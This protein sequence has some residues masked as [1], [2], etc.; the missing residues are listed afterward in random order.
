MLLLY[1]WII[2]IIKKLILVKNDCLKKSKMCGLPWWYF[3]LD[4]LE[5]HAA[6]LGT[7]LLVFNADQSRATWEDMRHIPFP[8]SEHTDQAG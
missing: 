4:G 2:I 1:S 5:V 8:S 3:S 6:V 7:D